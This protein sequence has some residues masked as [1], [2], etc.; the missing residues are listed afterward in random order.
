MPNAI[1]ANTA[2]FVIFKGPMRTDFC[3]LGFIEGFEDDYKLMSGHSVTPDWPGDV[4]F[5]MDPDFKKRIKLSDN[6]VNSNDFLVASEPLQ[7]FLQAEAVP[8]VQYLP[9]TIFNHKKKVEQ[10]AY[11]IVNPVGLQD[12]VDL[13]A[14]MVVMNS[15]NPNYISI[16][17]RLVVDES[18]ISPESRLFRVKG[19]DTLIFFRRELADKIRTRG[20]TG[21]E[22][23][24][25]SSYKT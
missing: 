23:A 21:I 19:L 25:I 18:K 8:E 24:E 1:G 14:S 9:V 20:F 13:N 11:A 2:S 10:D 16:V 6:L 7:R 3:L 17:K 5:T 12:C 4:S 15:I 22:F